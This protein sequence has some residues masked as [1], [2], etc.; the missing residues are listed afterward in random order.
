MLKPIRVI[1]TAKSR[2]T[3]NYHDVV[4]A[5]MPEPSAAPLQAGLM[6][7]EQHRYSVVLP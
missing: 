5:R 7:Q 1:R 2:A 4:L 3:S 6:E